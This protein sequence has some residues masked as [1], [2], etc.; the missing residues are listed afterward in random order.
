MVKPEGVFPAKGNW[1]REPSLSPNPQSHKLVQT[2]D[3]LPTSTRGAGA[4]LA[5]AAHKWPGPLTCVHVAL[6]AGIY[7]SIHLEFCFWL[8]HKKFN[9][10]LLTNYIFRKHNRNRTSLEASYSLFGEEAHSMWSLGNHSENSGFVP[11]NTSLEIWARN[12][13]KVPT[14]FQDI[15]W[16]HCLGQPFWVDCARK[17]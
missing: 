1:H 17:P 13:H 11:R 2:E 16:T 10:L 8:A 9:G 3:R 4:P 5:Q 7:I 12:Y 6:C 14:E 15:T